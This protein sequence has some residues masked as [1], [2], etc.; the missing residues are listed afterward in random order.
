M[1]N[2]ATSVYEFFCNIVAAHAENKFIHRESASDKEFHFQNWVKD[3]LAEGK[4]HF[5]LVDLAVMAI[6]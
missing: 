6:L 3:R 4:L 2:N 5:E 1:P